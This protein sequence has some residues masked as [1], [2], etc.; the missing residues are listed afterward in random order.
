MGRNEVK[1]KGV[2]AAPG[3]WGLVDPVPMG[4]WSRLLFLASA[5]S[6]IQEGK[7][8]FGSVSICVALIPGAP[9]TAWDGVWDVEWRGG[10]DRAEGAQAALVQRGSAWGW[11]LSMDTARGHSDHLALVEDEERLCAGPAL[12]LLLPG[13]T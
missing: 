9:G 6:W 3:Q 8:Q 10:W 12:P 2:S 7:S 5:W 13:H 11:M 1:V 4:L